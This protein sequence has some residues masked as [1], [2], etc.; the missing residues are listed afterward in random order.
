MS[1]PLVPILILLAAAVAAPAGAANLDIVRAARAQVGVTL[2]YDPAYQ[3]LKYPGGDIPLERGVCADVVVRAL[4][5]SR[6]LDLQKLV[7]EDMKAHW[8]EYPNQRRWRM[9]RPDASIDHRRVPNLM[10]YFTRAGY[11]LAPARD[12]S[13]YLPGDV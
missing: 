4:R 9:S 2:T 1:A 12:G 5:Q 6:E 11:S 10:T 13:G 7:H 3:T 8:R